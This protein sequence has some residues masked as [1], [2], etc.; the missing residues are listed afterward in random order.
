MIDTTNHYPTD[1]VL[2]GHESE[3]PEEHEQHM[4]EIH[5]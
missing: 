4:R 5:D 2:C 1:C 3:T